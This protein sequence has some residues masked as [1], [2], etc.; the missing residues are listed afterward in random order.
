[1]TSKLIQNQ[2]VFSV[3]Q[4]EIDKIN[5]P[6][7]ENLGPIAIIPVAFIVFILFFDKENNKSVKE[8]WT[9]VWNYQI[10]NN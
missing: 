10:P 7:K 4:H 5:R 9:E 3:W 1:M 6:L 8:L 2:Q